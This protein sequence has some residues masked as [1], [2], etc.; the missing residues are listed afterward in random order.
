MFGSDP[1][2]FFGRGTTLVVLNILGKTLFCIQRLYNY[3]SKRFDY[4]RKS[5]FK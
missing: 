3:V 2:V 5:K 1:S 4:I